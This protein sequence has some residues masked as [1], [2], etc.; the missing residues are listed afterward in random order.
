MA[1]NE[2]QDTQSGPWSVEWLCNIQKGDVGLIS[3]KNKRMKKAGKGNSALSVGN[4]QVA[5]KR[6][7]GGALR[8]PVLTLKKVARLPSKDRQEVMKVLQNSQSMQV[9]KQKVR[10]RKSQREKVSKSLEVNH[11]S[12]NESG[13]VASVNN[14]WKNWVVLRGIA[15]V[16][17]VDIQDIGKVVGVYFEGDVNNK[18]SVLSR[19]RKV[20]FGPILTPVEEGGQEHGGGV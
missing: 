2:H 5:S 1:R 11:N 14:D 10:N 12:N 9:L 4:K 17:E 7:A 6:N 13:S 8:H 19:S 20:D 18:F 16:N 3:S 15:K